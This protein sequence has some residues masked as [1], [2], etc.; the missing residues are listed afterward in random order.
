MKRYLLF[1]LCVCICSLVKSQIITTVA[2]GGTNGVGDGGQA[3]AASVNP[4][5]VMLDGAGN[6]Y[7]ADFNGNRIRK[8]N[9]LG[10]ISTVA[11]KGTA[12]FSGDGGQA[13]AAKISGP[14]GVCFDAAGNMFIADNDNSRIRKVNTSGIIETYA[15]NG[16]TGYNGDGIQA[17]A[18]ELFFPNSMA[19]DASGNL[20]I[21]DGANN[22]IRKVNSSGIITTVAGFGGCGNYCGDGGLATDAGLY[23]PDA[24]YIDA[25]A[26]MYLAD[27]GNSRIRLVDNLGVIITIA[28]NGTSGYTG[29]GGQA[30]QA[31]LFYPQGIAIDGAGNLF[32]ADFYDNCIRRVDVSGTITTVVGNGVAGFGGDG[33]LAT[34]ASIYEPQGIN[35]D[36]AGNLY[37]ADSKNQR[38]RKVSNMGVA[39]I[40]TVETPNPELSMYPNPSQGIFNIETSQTEKQSL[41][42]FD[43]HGTLVLSEV[44]Y[45]KAVIDART[46]AEGV[47]TIRVLSNK[48]LVNKRLV[49]V[50]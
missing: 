18:A 14:S 40:H 39:S 36:A 17:T 35:F 34:N 48:G 12:G 42:M 44:I 22:S 8:V 1:A 38:V 25:A 16:G 23:Q 15:G 33:G 9:S 7:I 45:D 32:I 2:G 28:G 11:G 5:D 21:V 49:I 43:V 10:V 30:I 3:T 20:Y 29:D 4:A 26:N 50:K 27:A 47:Y 31:E 13:T 41:Q 37:I 6:L 19:V 24:I 46:L